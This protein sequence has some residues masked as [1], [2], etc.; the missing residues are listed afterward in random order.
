DDA[1]SNHE[2]IDL[3]VRHALFED[4][5]NGLTPAAGATCWAT[6]V[7]C[8]RTRGT[9]F[10]AAT[11]PDVDTGRT[12]STLEVEHA[13]VVGYE[14]GSP[15]VLSTIGFSVQTGTTAANVIRAKHVRTY[16]CAEATKIDYGHITMEDWRDS[17]S[18]VVK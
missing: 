4:D 14:E 5:Q 8:L 6:N 18:D 12:E 11:Q 7:A 1:C 10:S 2:R 9:A 13:E 16:N 3:I 15:A 17:G